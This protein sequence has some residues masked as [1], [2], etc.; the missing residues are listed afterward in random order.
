MILGKSISPFA[1]KLS[2]E[3]ISPLIAT[4]Y[5]SLSVKPSSALL[6]ALNTLVDGL[7]SDGNWSE[8]DLFHVIGGLETDEQR[9]KPLKS[10]SGL[11]FTNVNAAT[12]NANGVAGNGTTSYLDL[13]WNP[14]THGVKFT[15]NSGL[16]SIYSRTDSNGLFGS[17]GNYSGSSGSFLLPRI[18][19]VFQTRV[20]GGLLN[21]T[22]DNS[23]GSYTA[24]RSNSTTL[25]NYQ[26]G[27]SISISAAQPSNAILNSNF[28]LCRLNGLGY[29][30]ARNEALIAVGSSLISASQLHSRV[31]TFF[32]TRG[33]NVV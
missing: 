3:Y 28:H 14:S 22:V 31:N 19:G 17:I 2:G 9:L 27:L 21:A 18:S 32:T 20:N 11:D 23:L 25:T 8:F 15:Q 12:L 13:N 30:S 24:I 5:N 4:W 29:F 6:N 7:N 16:L 33:I 10:T 1:V 26:N